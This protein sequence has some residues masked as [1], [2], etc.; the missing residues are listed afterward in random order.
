ME[1]ELYKKVMKMNNTIK[2][3]IYATDNDD[4]IDWNCATSSKDVRKTNGLEFYKKVGMF[5]GVCVDGTWNADYS[6]IA[7]EDAEAGLFQE[8]RAEKIAY[9]RAATSIDPKRKRAVSRINPIVAMP[10]LKFIERCE[11]YY[12]DA[13]PSKHV[14]NAKRMCM[15]II[16][17]NLDYNDYYNKYDVYSA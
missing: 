8:S 11:K 2:Q 1:C 14:E 13:K 16:N 3:W 17:K 10:F 15:E 12:K 6:L 7:Y 9:G 4:G 5:A